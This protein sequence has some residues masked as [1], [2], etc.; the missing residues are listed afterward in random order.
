MRLIREIYEEAKRL[1]DGMGQ[2][3]LDALHSDEPASG[4][5][6]EIKEG[7]ELGGFMLRYNDTNKP[8]LM[9]AVRNPAGSRRADY[10][11]FDEDQSLV[12]DLEL[13]SIWERPK[14]WRKE[15]DDEN[16]D[17][18]HVY[19]DESARFPSYDHL[20]RT[21]EKHLRTDYPPYWLVIYDNSN[22]AFRDLPRDEGARRI[23]QIIDRRRDRLPPNLQQVWVWDSSGLII[24]VV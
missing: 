24:R 22:R 11:V 19:I 4:E 8:N 13:T 21:I 15:S 23:R 7:L 2:G 5:L 18:M 16:P 14:T 1:A 20:E 9:Y 17:M 12:C 3:F 6:K 10:T